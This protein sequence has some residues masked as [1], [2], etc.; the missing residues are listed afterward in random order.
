MTTLEQLIGSELEDEFLKFD[1]TEIQQVLIKL[2]DTDAIDLAHAE[3]LQQQSLQAADT[4]SEFLARLIKTVSYLESQVN[5]TKNRVAL[6]YTAPDGSRATMEMRKFAAEASTEV[7]EL[8]IRLARAKG[9]KSLLEKKYDILI[10]S[11]HHYKDIAAGFKRG[12][13]GYSA[14][15]QEKTGWE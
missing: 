5:A 3:L 11:H 10:K 15:T 12:I 4:I 2:R 6:G 7:E 9:S 1:L 13:L 14:L 8:A